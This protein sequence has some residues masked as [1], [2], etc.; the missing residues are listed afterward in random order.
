MTEETK[1]GLEKKAKRERST[2][3]PAI[4]LKE[5]VELSGKLIES[6]SKSPFSRELAV[7]AIGYKTITGTSAPKVAALVHYGLLERSGNTYKNSDLASRI[8]DFTSEEDRGEAL[9]VAVTNPKL[10][11]SLI[12]EYSGKA[13][14][15]LL[16]NILVSQYKIGRKVAEGVA[17]TFKE[18]TEF[19]GVYV[20]GVITEVSVNSGED[21]A[22][23]ENDAHTRPQTPKVGV[24]A[25]K[26]PQ[27][28]QTS[29]S[30]QSVTLPSGIVISY[31]TEI[32]YL[33]AIGKFGGEIAALDKAVTDAKPKENDEYGNDDT[34][35]AE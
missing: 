17:E 25:P 27:L 28:D 4:S 21:D 6:Y 30:M 19:A 2:A 3:Y 10:F 31:P 1:K 8:M 32:A 9:I 29:H 16:K 24:G 11:S 18:S 33:F 23:T 12:S 20:N 22:S 15:G 34:S 26:R 35:A 7:Q 5:A 14:P 13:I